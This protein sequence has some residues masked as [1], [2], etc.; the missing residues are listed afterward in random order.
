VIVADT[1]LLVEGML[2]RQDGV[3]SIRAERLWPLR[4][5]LAAAIPSHDFR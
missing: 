3:T 5:R 1:N 2:Q 4:D